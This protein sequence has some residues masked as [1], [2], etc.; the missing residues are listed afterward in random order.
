MLLGVLIIVALFNELVMRF[1]YKSILH[2][3]T[4][5]NYPVQESNPGPHNHKTTRQGH[6]NYYFKYI[7]R[8][9]AVIVCNLSKISRVIV[10]AKS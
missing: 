8:P 10:G 2:M 9:A 5:K 6:N 7:L 4:T 1:S 3:L